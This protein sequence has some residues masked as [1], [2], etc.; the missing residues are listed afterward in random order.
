MADYIESLFTSRVYWTLCAPGD[1][2]DREPWIKR[3]RGRGGR[4]PASPLS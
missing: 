2:L 4:R 3:G 1:R